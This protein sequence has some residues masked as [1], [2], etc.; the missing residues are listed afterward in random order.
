MSGRRP[1]GGARFRAHGKGPAGTAPK[2]DPGRA[3]QGVA[4]YAR[5]AA[6]RERRESESMI[7]ASTSTM[8]VIM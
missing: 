5:P 4:A 7:T 6:R 3:C 1:N 2:S 8:P